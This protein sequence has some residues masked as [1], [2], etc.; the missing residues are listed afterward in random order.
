MLWA[1][2]DPGRVFSIN[3]GSPRLIEW[4]GRRANTAIWKSPVEGRV[5]V[6]GVNLAGDDQ[7]DRKVRGG[8]DKAVYAYAR[9]DAA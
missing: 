3:V 2:P 4:F 7:G 1:M 6:R 8:P 5:A 9:E